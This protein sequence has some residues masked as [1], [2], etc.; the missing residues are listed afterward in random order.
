MEA[1]KPNNKVLR[2]ARGEVAMFAKA[3][4]PDKVPKY[5]S[6][7]KAEAYKKRMKN[8]LEIKKTEYTSLRA[9]A[10]QTQRK[11]FATADRVAEEY[12]RYLTVPHTTSKT[13]MK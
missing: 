10:S 6:A 1:S 9:R 8:R 5:L 4:C 7:I 11:E 3:C 12:A 13:R 2:D